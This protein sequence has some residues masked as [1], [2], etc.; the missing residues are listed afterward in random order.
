MD[1]WYY[2]LIQFVSIF[3]D[4]I[5]IAMLVR[6]ILSWFQMGEGQSSVGQFLYVVT[7]PFVMPLRAL[8]E[9][10]GWFR[11]IPVDMPFLITMILLSFI[12]M[13]LSVGF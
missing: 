2:I 11:N 1:N 7:E 3:L 12:R 8:C 10:L 9:R 5:S 4:V 13:F 6:V